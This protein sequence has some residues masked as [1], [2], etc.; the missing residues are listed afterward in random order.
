MCNEVG[1]EQLGAQGSVGRW[2]QIATAVDVVID[3][4]HRRLGRSENDFS[5]Q[6]ETR[7]QLSPRPA[8]AH[9]APCAHRHWKRSR[10]KGQTP[11]SSTRTSSWT[12]T[13][14]LGARRLGRGGGRGWQCQGVF[15]APA[16]LG[17]AK[18]ATLRFLRIFGP[19]MG[20]S[21]PKVGRTPPPPPPAPRPAP[22]ARSRRGGTR[23]WTRTPPGRTG[24][25]AKF[26]LCS[27]CCRGGREGTGTRVYGGDRN[28]QWRKDAQN[29]PSWALFSPF[30]GHNSASLGPIFA[31]VRSA[32]PP[33]RP[34]RAP[35]VSGP[36]L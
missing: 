17:A 33:K 20:R 10:F 18:A 27:G 28:G 7:I 16:V 6:R 34:G 12:V 22:A 25:H 5:L 11:L 3:P 14:T 31:P 9:A 35:R 1:E 24:M 13:V 15:G 26:C 19:F 2:S 21:G 32:S 30:S 8:P 29:S 36:L 4:E 23:W